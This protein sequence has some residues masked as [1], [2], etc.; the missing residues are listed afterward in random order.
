MK[1]KVLPKR[2]PLGVFAPLI[3]ALAYLAAFPPGAHGEPVIFNWSNIAGPEDIVN[4][5]GH[6]FGNNPTVWCSTNGGPQVQSP[7]VNSGNGVVHIKMP[8]T[9]GLYELHVK[10][11]SSPSNTVYVNRARP[12]H[13]D[14]PEVAA[15]GGFRIFGRNLY[16]M[17]A[18]GFKP[19]VKFL[20]GD[21]VYGSTVKVNFARSSYNV[22]SVRAPVDIPRG[23]YTVYV[24]N[25]MGSWSA[26]KAPCQQQLTI[27]ASGPDTFKLSVPWAADLTSGNN[28]YNVRTD[29]RL[30]IHAVGDGQHNDQPAIQ[31]TIDVAAQAGGGVVYLPS[32]NYKLQ[33]NSGPL[34]NFKN[35]VVVRGAGQNKTTINYGYGHPGAHFWLAMFAQVSACGICDLSIKNLNENDAWLNTGTISNNGTE[36]SKLFLARLAADFHNSARIELKGDRIDVEKCRLTSLYTLLYMGT[37]SNSRVF[38]NT[39]TQTL[40]VHLDL[41][42][43]NQCLVEHNTFC[44]NANHGRLVPGNVRHGMSIGFAHNLAIINNTWTCFGGTPAGNND[45]EA[46]LSEGGGGLRPGEETGTVTGADETTVHASKSADYTAGT[47]IAIINGTGCGQWRCISARHGNV[48]TVDQPW[49]VAPDSKSTYSIFVWSN[50]N[51]TIA[52]NSFSKW[53]RGIWLYQGSTTDTQIADNRLNHMDGIFIEPCQNVT[54]DLGQFNPVWNTTVN[55]NTLS[56]GANATYINFTGDLQQTGSLVGAMALNDQIYNNTITCNGSKVYQNDPAQTEGFCNYLRVEAASYNDQSVAAM[57]GIVFQWNTVHNCRGQ[58]Y[59]IN[60]GSY[61]TTIG[62]CPDSNPKMLTDSK[63]YWNTPGEHGA[64]GTVILRSGERPDGHQ[65]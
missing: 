26:A 55:N 14:T 36:V 22:L 6:D 58:A 4:L 50:Q 21:K 17:S 53:L 51:T 31:H 62:N 19:Q 46:I 40:G 28:V 37:C 30:D 2:H 1:H 23:T 25:G 64:V 3:L 44:L 45:G 52:G 32:G 47:I 7:V 15:G 29:K 63:R 11:G 60:G 42:N 38:G 54:R 8:A 49:A 39:L 34:L 56:S 27:R 33:V 9:P 35:N 41:T 57:L 24:S 20:S 18:S 43:S 16:N 48:I 5:Q 59:L 65:P 12:M 10:N 13:F 61:Q